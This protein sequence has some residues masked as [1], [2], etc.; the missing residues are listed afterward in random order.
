[1]ARQI[2]GL[3]TFRCYYCR[4]QYGVEHASV[5]HAVPLSANGKDV[6]ENYRLSCVRCNLKK[7]RL[8]EMEFLY[9]IRGKGIAQAVMEII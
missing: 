1:M 2:G 3:T 7:G 5:D 8:T 6:T 4:R 9:G